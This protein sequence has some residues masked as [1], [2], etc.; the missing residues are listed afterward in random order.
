MTHFSGQSRASLHLAREEAAQARAEDPYT[1]FSDLQQRHKEFYEFQRT[2]VYR[3]SPVALVAPH[4]GTMESGTCSIA[5]QLAGRTLS[6]YLFQDLRHVQ[7]PSFHITSTRF[8]DP[9]CLALCAATE[10]IITVHGCLGSY[11]A[12]YIGGLDRKLGLAIQSIAT[13][14][15]LKSDRDQLFKGEDSSNLC[16]RGTSKA[17]VQLEFTQGLRTSIA[18]G[19]HPRFMDAL[20]RLLL[21][22]SKSGL[23]AAF[24]N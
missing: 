11:E 7:N 19:A 10:K 8:D 5:M 2:C 18:A 9:I 15:G 6:H 3:F 20:E 1:N 14:C 13:S 16:N 12:L 22:V 24:R 21:T 23:P 17:G 4:G